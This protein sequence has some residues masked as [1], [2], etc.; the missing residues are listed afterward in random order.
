MNQHNP[1]SLMSHVRNLARLRLI[2]QAE[3]A[4]RARVPESTL[5]RWLRGDGI[6]LTQFL[7]LLSALGVT[8]QELLTMSEID[9]RLKYT[10]T[11]AQEEFFAEQPEYLAYFDLLVRGMTPAAIKTK[12]QLSERTQRRYLRGLRH[13]KLIEL[14]AHDKVT[15]KINGEPQWRKGGP[16]ANKLRSSVIEEFTKKH[17]KDHEALSLSLQEYDESDVSKI[18]TMIL[19]LKEFAAAAHRRSTEAK[20]DRRWE[21]KSKSY[22]LLIG[23]APYQASILNLIPEL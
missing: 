3:L 5:K 15:R 17:L 20:H 4:R 19:E 18:K 1:T 9:L 6:S 7:T 10:Y 2:T 16:L 11:V 13:L 12:Y 22:G 14:G 8:W 23:M 21:H